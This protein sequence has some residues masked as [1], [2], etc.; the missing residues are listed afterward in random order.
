MM[1]TNSITK[2]E[3]RIKSEFATISTTKTFDDLANEEINVVNKQIKTF[4]FISSKIELITE[5]INV[6]K[7]IEDAK[8]IENVEITKNV[9]ANVI[10]NAKIMSDIEST[11]K[12]CDFDF[13]STSS[14]SRRDERE[15]TNVLFLIIFLKRLNSR[16]IILFLEEQKVS[17]RVKNA[18]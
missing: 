4:R 2:I 13:V 15:F 11:T 18:N 9:N 7:I 5:S 8:M 1:T 14:E 17:Y 3:M 6:T 12:C 16:L 10:E